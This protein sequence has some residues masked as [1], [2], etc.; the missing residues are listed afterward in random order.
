MAA[1]RL[2]FE[3]GVDGVECDVYATTDGVPVIIHDATTGRTAGAGTNLTVEASAWDD[4]KDVRVGAFGKWVGTEWE[5]ETLPKFED[6]LALLALNETSRCVVELKGSGSNGLIAAV[7]AAVRA[8]PLATKERVLFIAFD[9]NLVS[10]IRQAL[11]DYEAWLLLGTGTYTGADLVSRI[12]ACGATGVDIS[13][14]ATVGEADIADVKAAGYAYAVWTIDNDAT[15]LAFARKGV[16]AV[17]TN[18]GGAMTAALAALV[19]EANRWEEIADA[20]LPAG[21][22]HLDVGAYV[23]DGLVAH[24]DGIRNA[25][26]RL[27]HDPDAS[28]WKNLVPNGTVA[29][30]ETLASSVPAHAVDGFWTDGSAYRFG[31]KEYFALADAVTL[32]QEVTVEAA[33]EFDPAEQLQSQGDK[34]QWPSL[35]GAV[36]HDADDFSLYANMGKSNGVGTWIYLKLN[37][38]TAQCETGWNGKYVNAVYDGANARLSITQGTAPNW[39]ASSKNGAISANATAFAI[40]ASGLSDKR[41][42]ERMFVGDIH[43]VRAY[44]RILTDEEQAWNR[45]VDEARFGDS[46]AHVNVVVESNVAGL[47]GAEAGGLYLVNGHHTFSASAV[48]AADG[49]EWEP[50]GYKLE[51]WNAEKLTWDVEGEHAEA[52]FAYTNC[53]ARP[54][55]RLTWNWRLKNGVKR[56]DA[57]SYVQA[58]LVLNFDGIRN[59]GLGQPHDPAATT[60][61]NLGAG[62]DATRETFDETKAAGAWTAN[63]YDFNAGEC[64]VTDSAVTLARQATLQFAADYNESVQTTKWPSFFGPADIDK[65]G[66]NA[67]TYTP[68]VGTSA[69]NRGDR[70]QFNSLIPNDLSV[71]LQPWDGR[72]GNEIIDYN[73]SSHSRTSA[74]AWENGTFK[75]DIGAHTYEI[76]ASGQ[77]AGR[78]KPRAYTGVIHAVRVYDRV[79]TEAEIG[80]NMEV[81]YVRF[82]GTAGRSTE[83][84][85]VEVRSEVPDIA[86]EDAGGWLVRGTGS[87]TFAAPATATVG[88]CAYA[89][90]GYRLETWNAA[91]RMWENPVVS[92]ERSSTVTGTSGQ[93]NRRITWLWTRTG[94]L[95]AAADYDVGDYVQQGLVAHYDG[96]R[97]RSA[98]NVH[99]GRGMF[100]RDLSY[101]AN[102]MVAA[103]NTAY[104]AWIDKGHHFTAAE[105]SSFQMQDGIS[106]GMEFTVESALDVDFAEQSTDYPFYFG[107]GQADYCMFTRKKGSVLEIKCDDWLGATRLKLSD[108]GGKYLTNIATPTDHYLFEGVERAGGV[109]HARENFLEIPAGNKM[110]IGAGTTYTG[111]GRTKRCMTGDYYA[112]R[113]Y[114]RA[115]TDAEVAQNRKVDEIRYRGKFADYANLTVVNEQP[116]EGA[117]A[118]GSVAD[119][120]YEL[121]GEWTFTAA[122]VV[123]DGN[124]LHPQYAV[125]TLVDGKWVDVA[126]ASGEVCTVTAG[127]API[128]LTWRWKRTDGTV[129]TVY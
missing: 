123:I 88:T 40:G 16:D 12:Q 35:F 90:A 59:A 78:R 15:A 128:L 125:E 61:K 79:L 34:V 119:G 19:V 66:F 54:K 42:S 2:A 47:E 116:A 43:S 5:G 104:A 69:L 94:G 60:W 56:Y 22:T 9:A 92:S 52:T 50:A 45:L 11:P 44:D 80:R 30:R 62:P 46:D 24:F 58:G 112:L 39:Q 20:S 86:L 121:T 108:W 115:L 107:F 73:R 36:Q 83:T 25:G 89:C 99:A 106:L 37:A 110:L 28:T 87:K 57:D 84:D 26:A 75:D 41:K 72:F 7:V 103:S 82:Y 65:D 91:K 8:Q 71:S 96:I 98:A 64:F 74:Y 81:D 53:V 70:L 38:G 114:N 6:Y 76:G 13:Q 67:Y 4:L 93:P 113:I 126:S 51:T 124:R 29:T 129:I 102:D 120:T 68:L 32:G 27:P 97:N 21:A 33:C 49:N 111:S 95:R 14:A 10:A 55:V 3:R 118:A 48:T 23:Q 63:G 85:L 1:F 31:G 18:R 101:R 127:A 17:T 100:W 77:S 122:P 105:E 109:G 117:N